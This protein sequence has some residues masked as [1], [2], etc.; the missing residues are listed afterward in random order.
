MKLVAQKR[1]AVRA[2]VTRGGRLYAT[3]TAR[4]RRGATKLRLEGRRRLKRG[5]YTVVLT[6]ST[7]SGPVVVTRPFTVR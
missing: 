5:R 3:G 4:L 6:V 2:R 7:K 1:A